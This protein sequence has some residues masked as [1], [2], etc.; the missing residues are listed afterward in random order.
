M[1]FTIS[2]NT[3]MCKFL[4]QLSQIDLVVATSEDDFCNSSACVTGT[5]IA[6]AAANTN[7]AYKNLVLDPSTNCIR[8]ME[9]D[10]TPVYNTNLMQPKTIQF[11]ASTPAFGS[12]PSSGNLSGLSLPLFSVNV[13]LLVTWTLLMTGAGNDARYTWQP[14][15]PVGGVNANVGDTY[16]IST[17]EAVGKLDS[18]TYSRVLDVPANTAGLS[19]FI[20]MT[21]N[22][23]GGGITGTG[24]WTIAAMA[25]KA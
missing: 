3:D 5:Y 19:C 24:K 8:W 7:L 11:T 1:L 20:R 13:K 18:S 25:F 16:G 23:S 15:G 9:Q 10:A 14:W 21:S 17:Q 4:T 6:D 12:L 22:Y 2:P